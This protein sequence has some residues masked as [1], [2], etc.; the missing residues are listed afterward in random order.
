MLTF[1]SSVNALGHAL[2]EYDHDPKDVE[3]KLQALEQGTPTEGSGP[4]AIMPADP[5][6][7]KRIGDLAARAEQP[8]ALPAPLLIAQTSQENP[9]MRS[10]ARKCYPGS[11]S[12]GLLQRQI[13]V[14]TRET[15]VSDSGD[16][17]SLLRRTRD[18]AQEYRH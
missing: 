18:A 9:D 8:G 7:L 2:S 4:T 11:T 17:Q 5:R 1:L 3:E 14:L 13:L 15:L 6:Y 12:D 16:K 10:A